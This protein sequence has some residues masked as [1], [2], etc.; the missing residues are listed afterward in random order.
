[1][2]NEKA[3]S[4][5]F[6][7][8]LCDEKPATLKQLIFDLKVLIRH[9]IKRGNYTRIRTASLRKRPLSKNAKLTGTTLI[10]HHGKLFVSDGVFYHDPADLV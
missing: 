6:S 4:R 3:T 8:Y 2:T 5:S 10:Y 1:M 9:I 7:Y